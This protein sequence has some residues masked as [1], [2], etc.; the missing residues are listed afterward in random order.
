VIA[1]RIG[2]I[3]EVVSDGESGFLSDV[4]DT[5]KMAEDTTRL[6]EDEDLRRAMGE[7]GRE[8]AVQRYGSD[9]IIPQYIAFYEKIVS[10]ARA[11]HPPS[12]LTAV[13]NES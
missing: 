12:A 13:G 10:K 2:G 9:K 6:I 11:E 4:G 5:D 7:K 8:T 1:T 3:P